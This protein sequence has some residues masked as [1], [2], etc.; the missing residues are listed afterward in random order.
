MWENG[1]GRKR[2]RTCAL[3]LI[4]LARL[5]KLRVLKVSARLASSIARQITIAVLAFPPSESIS[6]LVSVLSL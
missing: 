2:G 1:G 6:S 4:R 5:P 3:H